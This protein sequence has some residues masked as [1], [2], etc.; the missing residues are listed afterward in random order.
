MKFEKGPVGGP[1][2]VGHT[3]LTLSKEQREKIMLMV[4]SYRPKQRLK[5]SALY[6]WWRGK[7]EVKK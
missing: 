6:K 4:N 2:P 7:K 5:E 3:G 1:G